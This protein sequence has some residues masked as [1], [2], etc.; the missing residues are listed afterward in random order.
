MDWK[1]LKQVQLGRVWHQ[2]WQPNGVDSIR[3]SV[4]LF[5]PV[6]PSHWFVQRAGASV[7]HKTLVFITNVH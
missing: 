6:S 7:G 3:S 1:A 5:A 2:A 4:D